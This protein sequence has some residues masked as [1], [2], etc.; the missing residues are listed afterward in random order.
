MQVSGRVEA[1]NNDGKSQPQPGVTVE[2]IDQDAKVVQS[3]VSGEKGIYAFKNVHPAKWTVRASHAT[4]TIA[5]KEIEFQVVWDNTQ[6]GEA[7]RVT[8]YQVC[9]FGTCIVCTSLRLA[10]GLQSSTLTMH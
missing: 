5:N 7:I 10:N 8:G 3:S 4:W 6:V 2:L 9:R 1:K